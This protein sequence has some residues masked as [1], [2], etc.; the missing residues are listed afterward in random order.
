[1]ISVSGCKIVD[2]SPKILTNYLLP[3]HLRHSDHQINLLVE[4]PLHFLVWLLSLWHGFS[5]Y[6]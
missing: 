3:D 5:L 6:S 1:M 2:C 4:V